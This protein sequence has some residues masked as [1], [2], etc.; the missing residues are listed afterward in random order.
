MA[1]HCCS[2]ATLQCSM[3]I[4]PSTF[5]ATA[6]PL[7]AGGAPAG[8]VLDHIPMLNIAPFGMCR[9]PSNPVVAAATAAAS[10]TLTPMPCIPATASPWT[11]GSPKVQVAGAAAL[12]Q[13]STVSCMWGGVVSCVSAGQPAVQLA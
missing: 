3:G 7:T 4:A 8:N 2:G 13:G 12:D 10:G 11:P 6:R 5:S 9:S 1:L